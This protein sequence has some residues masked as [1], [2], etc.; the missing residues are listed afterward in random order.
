MR[1]LIGVVVL[2]AA[3]GTAWASSLGP[4]NPGFEHGLAGWELLPKGRPAAATMTADASVAHAGRQ[5]LRLECLSPCEATV[6]SLPVHLE[7]GRL[8]RLRGHIR[9][10]AAF[11]D[12]LSRYPTAVPATLSMASFP[13]TNYTPA[14]GA[15]ADWTPV[16]T[17]FVAT[18]S[19]DRIHL[20]LGR[21]GTATGTAWFDDLAV[22]AVTDVGAHVAPASVRW[23]GP[24]FR[25]D[26]RG[27]I[28]V[29]VEG[30]P[31][32][33]GYQH[34][35][36]LAEEIVAYIAKLAIQENQKEPAA[37]WA[38]LRGRADLLFLR[39]FDAEQLE[40]MRGIADGAARAGARYEG[41]AVDLLDI[42][43]LNSIIDLDYAASGIKVTPHALSGKS[44][45]GAAEEMDIPDTRHKCSAIAATAPATADGGVVFGQLFM[46]GGYTGVH[47]NVLCDLV[48]TKGQR[49]VYQTFP[50]GIH[51]GTDFYL[52]DAGIVFGETTVAQTPFD[53]RGTPQASRARRA[54]QY[55][56]S[57]D[58][59]V[60]ILSERNNGL[61][62]NDWPIADLN[63]GETAIF[64]LGTARSKLW[65]S[66]ERPAPFGTPGF[67]WANN[68]ARDNAV[69]HEYAVQP[70]DA[71]FDIAFG[72]HNR[73]LAFREFYHRF[74]GRID[75]ENTL[76]L[77]ASSPVNRPHACDGKLTTS[78][79]GRHMV[80]LAHHGKTTLR[81]KIP[82]TSR[83]MPD[84]PGAVPHLALGWAPQSPIVVADMLK[85]A[86]SRQPQPLPEPTLLLGEVA[87]RYRVDAARLWRQSVF[88]ATDHDNWL[89]SAGA[90]Y[91]R[92]LRELPD[93]PEKAFAKL[94]NQLAELGNRYLYVV[95][96]EPDLPAIRA[97]RSY[98]R[99][100]TYQIPRIKGTFALHQLR[101]ALGNEAFLAA[102]RAAHERFGNRTATTDEFLAALA[103][104]AR[105]DVAGIV[106]PWLEREGLPDPKVS[107]RIQP[108]G[109][110]WVVELV[111]RQDG[112]PWRL[113]GSVAIDA[114]G[115][116]QL[117]AVEVDGPLTRRSWRTTARPARV[118]FNAGNDFPVVHR[119]Y[120]AWSSFADD[121][122]HT[123]IV[124]GTARQ[125]EANHT[126]GVRFQTALADGFSEVL[127][128]LVKDAEL[129][130]AQAA[131]HDLVVLGEVRDNVV[132]MRLSDTLPAQLG[133]G[134]FRFR[135]RAYGHP[136]DG[137]FLVLPNP[138]N[139]KRTLYVVTA[140]SA[141]QLWRMTK[142]YQPTLASWAVARG[143]DVK[144]Q[145]F[146]DPERFAFELAEQ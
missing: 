128:P 110:E 118:V 89:T 48:P 116:R 107:V 26:D 25:Y 46:W 127:P 65:R 43:T 15:T 12:P 78:E 55:A 85:A 29:H 139:P 23:Q 121:F 77:L 94:A 30:E 22:E 114:G 13:F 130:A 79:M 105:R 87:P 36:L 131:S 2:G 44:F 32:A 52:N 106:R 138:F 120:F 80:F 66:S 92:L 63:T 113:W 137:L 119:N 58:D 124:Y 33:R 84:L 31:Y 88:P 74:K 108:A 143:D 100:G 81:E 39:G 35:S 60:R 4:N 144:E 51:S 76:Q 86:R 8:Y 123:L 20:H 61:Y 129:D 16:E 73:D 14:V 99:Y 38:S 3:L 95:A 21:N 101:L 19:V 136:D 11:S 102:M 133:P 56:R 49:L 59:V 1:F 132:L 97:E 41:R 50:G 91:W 37:G 47:F 126:V 75:A 103:A 112:I 142:A 115:Q 53:I 122:A 117:N 64:L 98:E 34:G 69:R 93:A 54:A 6:A 70:D 83:R 42:V 145:G 28:V 71:P 109:P 5:S 57:I 104:G 9:T 68:N 18:R 27:W 40:E 111:A 72:A 45:L 96:H 10:Q 141:L 90:A 135:G 146:F 134:F 17:V 82:G 125:A 140:N 7:V 67:L 24:G 62:T